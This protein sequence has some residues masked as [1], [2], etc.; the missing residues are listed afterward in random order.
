MWR[1]VDGQ[2]FSFGLEVSATSVIEIGY[3]PTVL[4]ND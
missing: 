4:S 3:L 1:N 2:I